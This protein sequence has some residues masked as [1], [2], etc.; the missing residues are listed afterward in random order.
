MSQSEF[1]NKEKYSKSLF[2]DHDSV[3]TLARIK[4]QGAAERRRRLRFFLKYFLLPCILI[5]VLIAF[6]LRKPIR[7][8]FWPPVHPMTHTELSESEQKNEMGKKQKRYGN[9]EAKLRIYLRFM[10]E[11]FAPEGIL[12]LAH[13]AI[14][15]KPSE[16][17]LIVDFRPKL[18]SEKEEYQILINDQETLSIG[19]KTINFQENLKE[20]DFI[21]ALEYMH[22]QHYGKVQKPLKLKLSEGLLEKRRKAEEAALPT[23]VS[24]KGAVHSK[25]SDKAI[26]LP[27]FKADTTVISPR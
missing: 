2:S 1:D 26:I 21:L 3:Q 6:A 20:K 17:F 4:Q 25:T 12:E 18:A 9:P 15:S 13:S 10:E 24:G 5:L 8:R 11:Q 27:D 7:Q 23:V 22:A 16:I 14:E 19:N